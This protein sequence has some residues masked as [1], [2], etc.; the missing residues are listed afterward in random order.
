MQFTLI[1][2][3][4]T[5][6]RR[7]PIGTAAEHAG[8]ALMQCGLLSI[9]TTAILAVAAFGLGAHDARPEVVLTLILAGVAPFVLLREFGRAF[10]F[11][12]TCT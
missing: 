10:A 12:H 9:L 5:V 4:Y 6:Q 7:S 8:N 1:S 2:L 3:P 11:S